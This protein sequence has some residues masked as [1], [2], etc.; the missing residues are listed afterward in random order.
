[1][2]DYLNILE[3]NKEN[4]VRAFGDELYEEAEKGVLAWNK[5]AHKKWVSRGRWIAKKP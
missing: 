1:M 4:I 2:D 5:A 3:N